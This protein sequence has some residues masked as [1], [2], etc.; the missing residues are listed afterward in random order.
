MAAPP[1]RLRRLEGL[2][3]LRAAIATPPAAAPERAA[4]PAVHRPAADPELFR[5]AIG[6]VRPLAHARRHVAAREL[7]A[8]LPYQRQ[9]DDRA[10]LKATLEDPIDVDTL[11]DTDESLSWRRAGTGP[12]VL[13]RLRR[14]VWTIQDELDLHGLRVDEAR[15]ALANFL[16][17]ALERGLRC[18]RIVHGKGLRSEGRTPVLKGRVRA[19]LVQRDDVIAFCQ[20]RPA[21]GGSGALV[22]L[23]RPAHPAATARV[24]RA[25]APRRP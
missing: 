19:W 15:E 13:R 11:L 18:L 12:D 2:S 6:P 8:P 17:E 25:P 21:Q 22:V 20:A 3:G 1:R 16:R 4:P 9:R 7:P 10:V 24:E 14:G 5:R 23:L